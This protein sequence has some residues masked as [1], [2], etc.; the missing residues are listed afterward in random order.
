MF[1]GQEEWAADVVVVGGGL[2]GLCA[3]VT[4]A[5]HGA[6]VLLLESRP[7]LGGSTVLSGGFFALAETEL[8]AREG[9]VDSARALYDDLRAVGG[10]VNDQALVQRYVEAQ[11]DLG[12]W[13][14]T[15]GARFEAVE[16]SSGQSV[17]RSHRIDPVTLIDLLARDAAAHEAITVVTE[18]PVHRLLRQ[19]QDGPVTGVL[20]TI[21]GACTSVTA[22]SGVVLAAGGFS[23]SEELLQIFAPQQTGALRIG[24]AGNIGT[25]L[26]MAWALGAD[27]RDMGSIKGTFGT[28]PSATAEHHELLL[29][30]Y[31][32]A[33]IVNQA[34]RRFIDESVSYKLIGDACLAQP[35][36]LGFQLFDQTV[37]DSSSPGV[38]LF[39]LDEPLRR[40]LLV[41]GQTWRELAAAIDVDGNQLATTVERYNRDIAADTDTAFGRDGLCQHAGTLTPLTRPPFYAFPSTTALLATY[42][43]LRITPDAEVIDVFDRPIEGLFAAGEITG[44]FHGSAYMTGSSLGKA[45][46]FGRIAGEQ[47]AQ[48]SPPRSDRPGTPSEALQTP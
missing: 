32:G 26:R 33:I 4:A 6:R 20:A 31:L 44:G 34:G 8:Q 23:R 39:D 5:E 43:G 21:D 38:P 41:R 18:A 25:G 47:T 13:L 42:C 36:A 14:A 17:A 45:A 37:M 29:A 10:E 19:S 15:K 2:A 28:H 11:A 16:L 9:I 35:G 24:G 22:R 46:V 48:A 1:T 30:F 40:G 3:A 27:L 12:D 7:S